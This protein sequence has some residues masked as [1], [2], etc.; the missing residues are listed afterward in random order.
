MKFVFDLDG[1]ITSAET[2]PIIAK[3]FKVHEELIKL[4]KDT[5]DGKIP[6]KQ[7]FITRVNLLKHVPVNEIDILLEKTPLYANIVEFINKNHDSCYIATG[8]LDCWV[9][10]LCRKVG[11][12]Y[13]SSKA[14]VNG[15]EI[16]KITDIIEKAEVVEKLQS[17]GDIV[18]FIGDSNNDVRAM[19]E[20][21]FSIAFGASHKP[22]K[23]CLSA[24]DYVI[25]NEDDL[26][27]MLNVFLDK[28]S[29]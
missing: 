23:L 29:A 13:Y 7:S 25:Y 24:A 18:I 14:L 3:T 22:S 4:T 21:D 6:W 15:N 17:E 16:I 28:F 8:N 20:A 5:V 11:C 26:V 2:L 10:G 27:N 9:D 12:Q 1:T 19:R